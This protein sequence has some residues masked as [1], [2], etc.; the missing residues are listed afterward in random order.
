MNGTRPGAGAR[1]EAAWGGGGGEPEI[2]AWLRYG[3]ADIHD[4]LSSNSKLRPDQ[5]RTLC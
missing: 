5:V 3:D 2:P 1:V 4:A